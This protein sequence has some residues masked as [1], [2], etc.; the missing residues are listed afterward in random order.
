MVNFHS[1][2][3]TIV[4]YKP[5]IKLLCIFHFQSTLVSLDR[6]CHQF[7]AWSLMFIT[8]NLIIIQRQSGSAPQQTACAADA[9]Q[10][11]ERASAPKVGQCSSGPILQKWTSVT[12]EDQCHKNGPVLQKMSQCC[13]KLASAAKNGPVLQK[14][15]SA[16]KMGQ[17]WKKW[18]SVRHD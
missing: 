17:C 1:S 4:Y 7:E 6:W 18:A 10:L 8:S 12:K 11:C 13:K 3:G 14:M 16:A 15:G 9:N 5:Q 2:N